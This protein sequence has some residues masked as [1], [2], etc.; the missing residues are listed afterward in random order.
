MKTL[1]LVIIIIAFSIVI[2]NWTEVDARIVPQTVMQLYKESDIILVGNDQNFSQIN[3]GPP[4]QFTSYPHTTY[5]P[6]SVQ[7]KLGVKLQDVACNNGLQLVIRSMDDS[8]ACVSPQTAIK[9]GQRS[10]SAGSSLVA[11]S[12]TQ[13][14]LETDL[15]N[16]R[17]TKVIIPKNIE[18]N[19]QL[20]L[21]PQVA[22][23]IL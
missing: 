6:P 10:W 13:S 19:P 3:C 23:V 5:L 15:T 4:Y 14:T 17:V 22:K 1:H 21:Q 11:T 8:P 12:K 18:S 9:I 2:L 20:N 7:F 16:S